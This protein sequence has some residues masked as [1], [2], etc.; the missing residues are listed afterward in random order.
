[1][2]LGAATLMLL[3]LREFLI[4][5]LTAICCLRSVTIG[6]L[7]AADRTLIYSF[8]WIIARH[9]AVKEVFGVLLHLNCLDLGCHGLAG[10]EEALCIGLL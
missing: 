3:S 7:N 6:L 1:M 8:E 4:H 5:R 2:H 9:I 10:S